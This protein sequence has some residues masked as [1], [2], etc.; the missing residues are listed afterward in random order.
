MLALLAQL[1]SFEGDL[2]ANAARA[3][4][5]LA[6]HPEADIAVFPELFLSGYLTDGIAEL[7]CAPDAPPLRRISNA[8][9][10]AGTAVVLGFP[11]RLEGDRPANAVACIDRDGSLAAIYRKTQLFGA[12]REA[13]APG[14]ELLVVGLAGR[15]VAPLVCFDV[16][17]P[18]PARQLAVSGVDLIAVSSANM[19]PFY[20]DHEVGTRARALENRIPV[21]Y[22]NAVGKLAG[23][24]FVGGSRSV[25]PSGEVLAEEPEPV[26]RLLVAEVA[27]P[28]IGD[29]RVDYLRHLP[30]PL[31]V[32]A[33]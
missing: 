11:E 14:S 25:A 6:A 16:E 17:F 32:V 8:A 13:F 9:A 24:V 18:E 20:V 10:A 29:E 28:G 31:P 2:E 19:E 21:V 30:A 27:G 22:A 15:R 26:E 3:A 12:E 33:P 5:A 1:A 23:L 4:E 7:A